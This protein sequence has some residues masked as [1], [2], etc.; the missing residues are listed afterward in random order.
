[1]IEYI[2]SPSADTYQPG[3]CNIGPA[4]IRRRR[5][6]GYLGLFASVATAALLLVIGAPAWTALFVALPAA[7]AASGFIQARLRFCAGYGM[8][9][10]QNL[11]ALGDASHIE[12]ADARAADRRKA[13]GIHA[14]SIAAGLAAAILVGLL[15]L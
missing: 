8:A 6:I 11:G 9:G 4:E 12:D 3:A 15:L 7:G 10:L 13:L 5:Q 1:M 2:G 14:A